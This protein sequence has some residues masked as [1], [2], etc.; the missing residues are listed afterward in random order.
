MVKV[1]QQDVKIDKKVYFGL[2][3]W[4]S[5]TKS[6]NSDEGFWNKKPYLFLLLL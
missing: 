2:S 4:K 3:F 6:S 1:Y 5:S